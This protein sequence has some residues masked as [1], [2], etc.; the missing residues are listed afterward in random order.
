MADRGLLRLSV[1]LVV[2]GELLF[3]LVTLF[4][5]DGEFKSR[6]SPPHA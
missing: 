1:T 2:I 3:A 6:P 5:P 4:H